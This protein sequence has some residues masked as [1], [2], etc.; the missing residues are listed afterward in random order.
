MDVQERKEVG[1]ERAA[2]LRL[3]NYPFQQDLVPPVDG[4]RDTAPKKTKLIVTLDDSDG[5]IADNPPPPAVAPAPGAS[6]KPSRAGATVLEDSDGEIEDNPPPPAVHVAPAPGKITRKMMKAAEDARAQARAPKATK[7]EDLDFDDHP[8]AAL[9]HKQ[10]DIEE[11]DAGMGEE[12]D[13]E[14]LE[15]HLP[16]TQQLSPKVRIS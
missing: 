8:A 2:Q 13:E 12:D 3:G 16:E 6:T 11:G 4:A 5:E 10:D 14:D 15:N 1:E 7:L 9:H